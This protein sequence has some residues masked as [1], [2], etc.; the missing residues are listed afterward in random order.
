MKDSEFIELLNLYLDH[1]ISAADAAKLEAEVQNSTER[2]RV[3]RQYCRMQKACKLAGA[4]FQT[5]LEPAVAARSKLVAFDPTAVAAVQRKRA[6]NFYTVG[7]F[8]A[9]AACVAIIFVGRSRSTQPVSP[10]GETA[11]AATA[12]AAPV[13]VPAVA[14]ATDLP[15][16]APRGLVSIA[17]RPGGTLVSDPLLLTNSARPDA[18]MASTAPDQNQL[19][20]IQAVQ[21]APVQSHVQAAELRFDVRPASLRP[22]G[23]SLGGNRTPAEASAEMAAFRFVK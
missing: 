3:Y 9:L 10:S 1:E 11:V 21:L 2:R 16:A 4:D 15:S 18:V 6:G 20:W 19:A 17:K 5:S 12:E 14:A 22:E 13:S 7:T 23:R 8:A